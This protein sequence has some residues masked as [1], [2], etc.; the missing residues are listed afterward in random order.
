MT[1]KEQI[2]EILNPKIKRYLNY[3]VD[4]LKKIL[5]IKST[6]KNINSLIISKVIDLTELDNDTAQFLSK[7]TIFKTINLNTNDKLVESMSFP[8]I[9]YYDMV[10][11]DWLNSSV[12][13]YFSTKTIVIFIFKKTDDDSKFLGVKYL[14]LSSD[15]LNEVFLVWE[16]VKNMVN[17]NALIIGGKNGFSV[18][19]F[20]KKEDN[21]VTHIRPHDQSSLEGRI[22]LPNGKRIINY[23]FWLN[24]S[25]IEKKL[26]E[27]D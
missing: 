3:S 9:D 2:L 27:G 12:Y 26:N 15:E 24:N 14:N 5:E 19:N 22:L 6:A 16:K 18:E 21:L 25:F 23:C 17:N 1:T 7:N 13:K 20:P 11:N 10:K 8:A 4:D